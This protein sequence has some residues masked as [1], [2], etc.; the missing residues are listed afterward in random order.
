MYGYYTIREILKLA[1]KKGIKRSSFPKRYSKAFTKKGLKKSWDTTKK[2][3]PH[4]V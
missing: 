4:I 3:Y 2:I 1:A